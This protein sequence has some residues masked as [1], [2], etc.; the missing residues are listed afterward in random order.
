MK[1]FLS[2][3]N[4]FLIALAIFLVVP[5]GTLA[6]KLQV[7]YPKVGGI[8][9]NSVNF[10]DTAL[11]GEYLKYIYY[12]FLSIG[13]IAAFV[14]IVW[15]GIKWLASAG[16]PG[17]LG[18]AKDIIFS[19]VIGLV[20]LLGSYLILNTI[21]PDLVNMQLGMTP[22]VG[23]A[24]GDINADGVYLCDGNNCS[25]EWRRTTIS[26]AS[27]CDNSVPYQDSSTPGSDDRICGQIGSIKINGDYA[28]R[29]YEHKNF[30]GKNICFKNTINNNTIYDLED[31]NTTFNKDC[32]AGNTFWGS[33][34]WGDDTDSVDI[35]NKDECDIPGL[36]LPGS[37]PGVYLC[38]GDGCLAAWRLLKEN[39]TDVC[40]PSLLEEGST[41]MICSGGS[42]VASLAILGP[43]DVRL[44]NNKNLRFAE[45][46]DEAICFT[47]SNYKLDCYYQDFANDTQSVEILNNGDCKDPGV[48]HR[49]ES[50]VD[51]THARNTD[52]TCN[53]LYNYG[54]IE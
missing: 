53:E 42:Q 46:G 9:L 6:L 27:I 5:L 34:G 30:E 52:P 19:A 54:F 8:D 18:E 40:D 48:M 33:N 29:L 12:F 2:K 14:M 16:N 7:N 22:I 47:K 17:A 26:I 4:L 15:G 20:I 38:D 31:C 23:P 24:A 28:V 49:M 51:V 21:N 50:G 10:D 35:I 41:D 45:D 3:K 44:Y 32:Q 1:I 37:T 25:V 36:T 39:L 11:F 43:Y 13:G